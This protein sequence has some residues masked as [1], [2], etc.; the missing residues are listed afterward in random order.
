MTSTLPD[1]NPSGKSEVDDIKRMTEQI[2]QYLKDNV[3][4]NRERSIALT[5]YEQAAMW[6]VKANFT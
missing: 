6:A 4:D 2:I 5:N 3:T 1:F